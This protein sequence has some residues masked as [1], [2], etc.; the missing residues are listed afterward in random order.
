MPIWKSCA[1][2]IW[3]LTIE[4]TSMGDVLIPRWR[5]DLEVNPICILFKGMWKDLLRQ[6]KRRFKREREIIHLFSLRR[7]IAGVLEGSKRLVKCLAGIFVISLGIKTGSHRGQKQLLWDP[8]EPLAPK[9]S[10][11]VDAFACYLLS[12]NDPLVEEQCSWG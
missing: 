7:L 9:P 10:Y 1:C 6:K 8:P 5:V 3:P 2:V 11:W 12:I 4:Y